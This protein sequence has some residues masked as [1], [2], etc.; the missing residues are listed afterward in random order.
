MVCEPECVGKV[1][2]DTGIEVQSLTVMRWDQ[3]ASWHLKCQKTLSRNFQD[4]FECR[5]WNFHV[6]ENSDYKICSSSSSKWI[7]DWHLNI[8][9]R[10]LSRFFSWHETHF[11]LAC[12]DWCVH[13]WILK[14]PT[15]LRLPIWS[16]NLATFRHFESLM[17]VSSRNKN[18]IK[19]I[20]SFTLLILCQFNFGS[21]V[22]NLG[23]TWEKSIFMPDI[24]Y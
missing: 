5:L 11:C 23:E 12:Y 3:N 13:Y 8:E 16:L 24:M 2:E 7:D 14:I 4:W 1:F 17:L 19:F 18:K 6:V 15:N 9:D 21:G 22:D 20:M 10:I